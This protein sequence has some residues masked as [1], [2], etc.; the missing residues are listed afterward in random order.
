MEGRRLR[1]GFRWCLLFYNIGRRDRLRYSTHDEVSEQLYWSG[2][3]G[4]QIEGHEA[5]IYDL[6]QFLS[7]DWEAL[8]KQKIGCTTTLTATLLHAMHVR[9]ALA[10]WRIREDGG[11]DP[12]EPFDD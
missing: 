4:G 11:L 6:C 5:L 8:S 9:V 10:F 12:R 3:V 2:R 7:K 1:C